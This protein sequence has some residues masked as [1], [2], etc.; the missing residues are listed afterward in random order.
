[1]L[2]ACY[3]KGTEKECV[4]RILL[5]HKKRMRFSSLMVKWMQQENMRLSE[6]NH[7]HRDKYYLF[8]VLKS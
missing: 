7:T 6:I 5:R 8:L 4:D 2:S 1:M 3:R